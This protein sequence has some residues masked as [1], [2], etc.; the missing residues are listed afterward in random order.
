MFQAMSDKGDD[1][2]SA[3]FVRADNQA[4]AER[5]AAPTAPASSTQRPARQQTSAPQ[6]S[7]AD[8]L[9]SSGMMDES[10]EKKIR[11]M[12]REQKSEKF[13]GG[14]A[15]DLQDYSGPNKPVGR[16]EKEQHHGIVDEENLEERIGSQFGTRRNRKR[17]TFKTTLGKLE[18]RNWGGNQSMKNR[19]E[20]FSFMKEAREK[21]FEK[22]KTKKD[23]NSEV[24]GKKTLTGEIPNEI[25]T[26]PKKPS[27]TGY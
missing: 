14:V 4:R 17:H 7:N 18:N 8:Y 19:Y 3:D 6:Q 12:Y 25:D 5:Q 9:K 16:S 13:T 20:E 11:K 22:V 26:E 27:M 24:N 1:A 15:A 2:T 23:Q 10:L 21:A